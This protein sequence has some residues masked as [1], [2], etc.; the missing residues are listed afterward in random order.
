MEAATVLLMLVPIAVAVAVFFGIRAMR[1]R[2]A[3][4]LEPAAPA[5]PAVPV[6]QGALLPANPPIVDGLRLSWSYVAATLPGMGGGD[7]YDAFYLDDGTLAVA[8]G[9]ADGHGL[10]ATVTMNVVRQAIRG[11]LIDGAKPADAL[12]RANRV[13]LRSEHPGVVTALVGL[14][15]PST[16][17]FRYASA[18]HPEPLLAIADE[19][20]SPLPGEGSGIALGVVPHHVTSEHVVAIPVDAVLAL[21]TDGC[22][23]SGAGD[24]GG[25]SV[26]AEA[27]VQA[28]MLAPSKP[29]L[30]IDRAIFG[31]QERGDDATIITITPEAQL[32]HLDVRLP[33]E[34]ASAAL[35]RTALRRYLAT[36]GLGERRSFD[37]L[38]AAGE[39]VANA[40]EHAYDR[41]PNQT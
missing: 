15:D 17:Q 33:A 41:R 16:L 5:R 1:A 29:A 34:G 11:S 6:L 20:C 35:A 38:V 25:A 9:D 7:F 8:I 27:L 14:I 3:P 12:R 39:A 24:A 10:T 32:A 23:H 4:A 19:T 26:L 40:I 13:L 2:H 31:E 21:Y 22:L 18:G 30:I 37:A 28:R 36:T